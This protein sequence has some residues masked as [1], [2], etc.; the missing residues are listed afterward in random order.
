[1]IFVVNASFALDDFIYKFTKI[2][3]MMK[4]RGDK[5]N[6]DHFDNI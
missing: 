5:V 2:F 4:E 3:Q 6:G 1:M